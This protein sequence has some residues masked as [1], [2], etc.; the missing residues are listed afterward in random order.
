MVYPG[1]YYENIVLNISINLIILDGYQNT[2]IDG[3]QNSIPLIVIANNCEISGFTI[4]NPGNNFDHISCASLRADSCNFNNNKILMKK[5]YH[6]ITKSAVEVAYGSSNIIINNDISFIDENPLIERGILIRN[7]A[8]NTEIIENDISKFGVGIEVDRKCNNTKILNNHINYNSNAIIIFGNKCNISHNE[9][10]KNRWWVITIQDG[11]DSTIF[12]NDIQG[13]N[14][15]DSGIM[16][17]SSAKKVIVKKNIVM[18]SLNGDLQKFRKKCF[19][20][21]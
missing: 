12:K 4:R 6:A 18:I 1:I 20:Q 5:V 3:S 15:E 11:E 16:I 17:Y 21:V 10:Y 7:Y 8:Y 19:L 9:L 14:D 2:I 13:I